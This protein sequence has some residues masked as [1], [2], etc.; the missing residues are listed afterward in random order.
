MNRSIDTLLG[1]GPQATEVFMRAGFKIIL[2]LY[3]FNEDDR[4]IQTIIDTMKNEQPDRDDIYW[5]RL[6]TRC[7]NII[8]KA[9]SAQSIG[10]HPDAFICYISL[11]LMKDPV[12]TPYGSSYERENIIKWLEIG[13]T[14]DP[15]TRNLLNI[16]QLYENRPLKQAISYYKKNFLKYSVLD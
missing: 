11:E 10:D 13:N 7:N 2:D 1:V 5:K 9:K 4:K 12:L 15:Y 8:F 16:N 14:T 6:G 3:H